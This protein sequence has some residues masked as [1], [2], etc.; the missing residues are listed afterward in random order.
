MLRVDR[1]RLEAPRL[2]LEALEGYCL[3]LLTYTMIVEMNSL[4]FADRS[5]DLTDRVISAYDSEN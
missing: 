1:L 2:R 5:L 3:R 4:L